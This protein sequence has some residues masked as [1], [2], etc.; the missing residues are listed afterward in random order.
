[1]LSCS[2]FAY[3]TLAMITPNKLLNIGEIS[4]IHELNRVIVDN[5]FM[6]CILIERRHELSWLQAVWT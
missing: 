2:V 5:R 3:L 6:G 1:M 4:D